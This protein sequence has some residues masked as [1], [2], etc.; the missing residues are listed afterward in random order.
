MKSKLFRSARLFLAGFFGLGFVYSFS[1]ATSSQ[2]EFSYIPPRAGTEVRA[3]IPTT[4]FHQ[5]MVDPFADFVVRVGADGQMVDAVC[6]EA[7]HP[8][9]IVRAR[10]Q[11]ERTRFQPGTI[12]GEPVVAD[13][14]I[15]VNFYHPSL[16]LDRVVV[17]SGMEHVQNHIDSM[18]DN[19]FRYTVSQANELDRPL[20]IRER[21]D[22]YVPTDED[23]RNLQGQARVEFYIDHEGRPR[24]PKVLETNQE[25]VGEAAILTVEQ[26]QFEPPVANRK[27]TVVKVQIPVNFN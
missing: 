7:T 22:T 8:D 2:V 13:M 5:R 6:L 19:P 16:E 26:W 3:I 24:L 11:L 17:Q 23:G 27:P 18:K 4:I 10:R 15:R 12:D 9:L 20:A 1:S 25:I 14:K 21:G